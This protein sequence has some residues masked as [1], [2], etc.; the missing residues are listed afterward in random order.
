M[1]RRAIKVA[2]HHKRLQAHHKRH[3]KHLLK[4]FHKVKSHPGCYKEGYKP[5][6]GG[7]PKSLPRKPK[8]LN[9]K[10]SGLWDHVKKAWHWVTG[11]AKKHGK[12]LYKVAKKHGAK[13]GT[14][15]LEEGKRRGTAYAEQALARGKDWAEGQAQAIGQNL[16]NKVEGYVKQADNKIKAVSDRIDKGVS[17]YTGGVGAMPGRVLKKGSG[18]TV[19]QR[20]ARRAFLDKYVR[21]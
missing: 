6:R 8:G 12:E 2:A 1:A 4:L 5:S 18:I 20:K 19:R 7:I 16:R 13:V 3:K 10:G 17:K 14:A 15:L 11:K 21:K 9:R